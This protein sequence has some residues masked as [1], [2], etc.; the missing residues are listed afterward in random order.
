MKGFL[1]VTILMEILLIGVPVK[2]QCY[3]TLH[4]DFQ[5][6]GSGSL[7]LMNPLP[8]D[9][10]KSL[11]V[12][13]L[14]DSVVW[15]NGDDFAHKFI[16]NVAQKTA[17]STRRTVRLFSFA[18]SGAV[19]VGTSG[20]LVPSLGGVDQGDPNSSQP[21][22][23]WSADCVSRAIPDAELVLIDG[24][25]N[26]VGAE[27]IAVP[28]PFNWTSIEQIRDRVFTNCAQPVDDLLASIQK[29]LPNATIVLNSYF[30][31]VSDKSMPLLRTG[32]T[33]TEFTSQK[34]QERLSNVQQRLFSES[35]QQQAFD[36]ASKHGLPSWGQRS[37]E[38]YNDT[39]DCF[40]WA[41]ARA[42]GHNPPGLPTNGDN[43]CPNISLTPEKATAS[44]HTYLAVV[45]DIAENAYGTSH[46]HLWKL[47]I[48]FLW[49]TLRKDEMFNK[50]AVICKALYPSEKD[51]FPC[52]IDAT[53]HPNLLGSEDFKNAV[54]QQLATA[55]KP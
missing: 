48:P 42:N 30:L 28:W 52:R 7:T 2:A 50:R 45:P 24:C 51:R 17:D 20:A 31:I 38:F 55:W 41:V 27:N 43:H 15:G 47:P 12:I 40:D 1:L 22:I 44:S 8:H 18:H 32:V 14:G 46:T 10:K 25:I 53:A 11:T 39:I 29:A 9:D 37:A 16:L 4:Q 33:P 35:G 19:L 23:K 49:W 6:Q 3:Q 13:A 26:D 34:E 54:F 21:N 5:P 36:T